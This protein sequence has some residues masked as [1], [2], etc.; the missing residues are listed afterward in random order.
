[1]MRRSSIVSL[2]RTLVGMMTV[3]LVSLLATTSARADEPAV[4]VMGTDA[5]HL[6]SPSYLP[7]LAYGSPVTVQAQSTS[8]QP[9]LFTTDGACTLTSITG[10]PGGWSTGVLTVTATT[11]TCRITAST[12]AGNGLAATASTYVLR[13]RPGQ[14]SAGLPVLGRKVVR[15]SALPLGIAG[16]ATDRGQPIAFRVT[17]GGENCKVIVKKGK[18]S[19]AFGSKQ[20]QCTVSAS[21][22]GVAG[23]YLPYQRIYVFRIQSDASVDP[24]ETK[25]SETKPGDAKPGDAKPDQSSSVTS[26]TLA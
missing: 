8:G 3:V 16:L 17:N 15:Q 10:T 25:P 2:S 9:V 14:Q 21:A 5:S 13:T 6:F 22:P 12:D 26:A 24:S 11:D 1:M 19:I 7:V 23:Q 18:V 20:G 4:I